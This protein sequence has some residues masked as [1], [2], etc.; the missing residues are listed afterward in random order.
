MLPEIINAIHVHDI[1]RTELTDV[2]NQTLLLQV[3]RAVTEY[4]N[5][6]DLDSP[7]ARGQNGSNDGFSG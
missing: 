5:E 4:H 2:L 3:D 6:M 1:L 7:P